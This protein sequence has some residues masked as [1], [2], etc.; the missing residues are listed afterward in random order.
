MPSA[1]AVALGDS[2][3]DMATVSDPA[4]LGV[5][6]G[7][8]SFFVCGPLTSPDGCLSDGTA[9]GA[10]PVAQDGTATSPSF[11]PN[12]TGTWCFRAEYSGDT[13]YDPSSDGSSEECFSVGQATPSVVSAPTN[14]SLTLG[15]GGGSD[16]VT[17]TGNS[18]GGSPSGTVSFYVCGPLPSASGCA[19]GGSSVG[20]PAALTAGDNNTATAASST[21]VP[22]SAGF[23]CF[24]SE[25]SGDGNYSSGSDGSSEECFSVGQATPSVVSTP[26]NQSTT[27]AA[28]ASDQVTVTG[29]SAGGSPSGTV[30]FF[31]CGPLES[32]SGCADGGTAVGT[33]ATLTAGANNTATAGSTNFLPSSAG[34]WCFRAEYSGDSNYSSGSDGSAGECFTVVEPGAPTAKIS[35]PAPNATYAVGQAV[36]ASYSCTEAS[37]GP[38]ISS[39]TGTVPNGAPIDTSTRGQHTFTVTATSEDGKST[40]VSVSYTVAGPPSV[41]ITSPSDGATYTLGE[42]VGIGYSCAEDQFGPGLESC[43]VPGVVDTSTTGTFPFT[44]TVTSLD[45]QTAT[46]TVHY[47]VVAQPNQ[48]TAPGPSAPPTQSTAA[49]NQSTA[50]PNPQP[51]VSPPVGSSTLSVALS[52]VRQSHRTWRRG[53]GLA[54]TA[55]V[56]TPI[57]TTFQFTLNES[58]QV[59]FAFTQ[60]LAG[61]TVR[62]RCVAPTS[63]NRTRRACTRTITRG[64]M[65]FS[66]HSGLNKLVFQGRLSRGKRLKPGRYTLII[67]ATDARGHRATAR[68]TFTITS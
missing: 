4:G 2:V 60:P 31:I 59:W 54:R 63:K 12:A 16:Q 8:V 22:P 37:G 58:A 45:G 39:C 35:S 53:G 14:Q 23:W 64:A 18:T 52:Q 43:S 13:N 57:G 50:A 21:F 46:A 7:T 15:A 62:G 26:S 56:H 10:V 66:G 30:S 67:T 48:S 38:G 6:S 68:L 40:P 1:G 29:N 65:S 33:P 61:R 3:S 27:L 49:P 55:S 20:T 41:A 47:N 32:A 5:P 24:R 19:D 34:V 9:L 44:A 42:V 25:Y 17:V 11:A 51:V 28:G 36:Q